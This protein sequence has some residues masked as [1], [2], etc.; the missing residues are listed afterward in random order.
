MTNN[1]DIKTEALKSGVMMW[2][3]ADS[4]GILDSAFSRMLRKELPDE[5]KTEIFNIIANIRERRK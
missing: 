2:E 5:K 3:I 4:M 1:I